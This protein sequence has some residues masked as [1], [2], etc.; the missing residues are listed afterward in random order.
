MGSPTT[1][2]SAPAARTREI[3]R[4]NVFTRFNAILGTMLV[5]ILVVG[6]I[7]D[8]TVRHRPGRQRADRH[9][10]GDPGQAH[11]RP[12][13]GAER[14][15]RRGSCATARCSEIAV[16]DGRARRP[17]RAA[18]RRPGAGRRRRAHAPT[19]SRSTSR[20]SPASPT[21]STRR[22]RRG[23]VGQLRRRGLGSLPGDGGRRRG[24]R[25]ASS[26]AEARRFTLVHSELVERHQPAPPA[27]PVRAVPRVARCCSGASSDNNDVD[28]ALVGDRRRRR[29]H[30]ARRA[31]AAH[32]PRVRHRRRDA[33]PAQRARAGAAG[34]RGA[35]P[36]RRRLPRQ[37]RHAHRGR[38]RRSTGSSCS[39]TS[40]ALRAEVARRGARR[41][42]RRR[43]PQRHARGASATRSASPGLDARPASVPFSSAR[44]WSAASF[45]GHGSVGARRARDG[46]GRHAADDPVRGARRRAR[47]RGE[48]ARC[49]WRRADDALDGRGRSRPTLQ[50]VA[51]V[52]LEE[53]V[54]PDAAETLALLR[55][56]RASTLKVISGD[57]PRTV[58]AVAGGSGCR[59]PT[60][61]YRRP[62]AARGRGRARR[63]ARAALGVRPGDAAAEAGDGRARCSR[64]GHVVA[65]TGD[66]VNDALALKDADI[67]VAMGSG[68]AATRAVAQLVLLDGKFA[69]HARRRRRGPAGD[70]A[71][72][73]GRRTC[74][75]PRRSTRC[76]SRSRS[77]ITGW[78]YPFLPR[79]L[80]I[81]STFTIGIPG[82]FLAL[83]PNTRRYIPGFLD[84]VLRFCIPAGVVAGRRVAR[85]V[86]PRPLR[87]GP[88]P[89]RGAHDRDARARRGAGCGCS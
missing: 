12:A 17:A 52:L 22:R 46:A 44:K 14:A 74:S 65:M 30:G 64:R 56:T 38:R 42:R 51:L 31:R 18:H 27:H 7:Q 89:A 28:D 26:R 69:T 57:N 6:A 3:V 1:P 32:E 36:R 43:E 48:P 10:P 63:R 88:P 62:R 61:A 29:R 59:T 70:R 11:A 71:T 83:A 73:S 47:G 25:A 55:A 8:A 54:R 15:R 50:P 79:H 77:C 49:C 20:C 24:V 40:A 60:T 86:L 75:S 82:F 81:V 85:H 37:D 68:A 87:R 84:R 2:A 35:G 23:A 21:R 39:P 72:S 9:R 76:S 16:E 45:D 34:G 41:A 19:G 53:K 58:A 4:A 78:R 66:G 67:G 5:V 13:R 33:R 80:T